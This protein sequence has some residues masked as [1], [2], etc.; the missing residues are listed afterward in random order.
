MLGLTVRADVVGVNGC[1]ET[2]KI[3]QSIYTQLD[4][5]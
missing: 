2:V 1:L 3:L 5:L 4:T